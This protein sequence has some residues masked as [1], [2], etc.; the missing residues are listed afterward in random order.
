MA[1]SKIEWTDKVWNCVRGCSIVSAGCKNCY[2]MKQAHRFSNAGGAYEGLTQLS[3]N[4][5]VWTGSARFVPEMLAAPLSWK[6]PQRV[7]VNSMSDLFHDDVADEEIAAAFGVMAA[8]PQH[9]FQI[10]TKRPERMLGW[11]RWIDQQGPSLHPLGSARGVRWYAW[12]WIDEIQASYQAGALPDWPW[13]LPNVWL[14]VSV[15]DQKAA[16]ERI[17]LLLDCPAA[18][19]FVSA[20][21]LLGTVDLDSWL[22]APHRCQ[23]CGEG[24][25]IFY[26]T[27]P[28]DLPVIG[29][30]IMGA[31]ITGEEG[32][33]RCGACGSLDVKEQRPLSW[34]IAGGESGPGARPCC[35]SWLRN[36]V[37]DCAAAK[38]PLFMKQ[39][40]AKPYEAREVGF[41]EEEMW[42]PEAWLNLDD[43]KGGD[44]KEW[45]ETGESYLNVR[46]FPEVRHG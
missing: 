43:K 23:A 31:P 3:K 38:I 16:D 45:V 41:D 5:P 29:E 20:E 44:P 15:E 17:P 19:H 22:Y 40:G 8:C 37:H 9:T 27:N 35:L 2:A 13:P 46:E 34:V 30:C 42:Q 6:K 33:A 7:F 39:L 36:I 28:H 10:L 14:G 11:F 18:V 24:K 12:N 1:D 4:G 32:A 21:P 25:R 26:D